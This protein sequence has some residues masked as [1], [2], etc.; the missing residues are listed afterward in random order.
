[1]SLPIHSHAGTFHAHQDVTRHTSKTRNT[2]EFAFVAIMDRVD[3]LIWAAGKHPRSDSK[4]RIVS[5]RS[6]SANTRSLIAAVS[7]AWADCHNA[8]RRL[9][10]RQMGP[11]R[12]HQ[13]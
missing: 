1:L 12:P 6:N 5:R 2:R 9:V 7:A 8:S 3:F 10:E 11:Q 13:R 4:G